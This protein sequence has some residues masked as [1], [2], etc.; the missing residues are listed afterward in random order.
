MVDRYALRS[1]GVGTH[2]HNGVITV[3][4]G[5]DLNYT[6][7]DLPDDLIPRHA[8]IGDQDR[9]GGVVLVVGVTNTG[10]LE[11]MPASLT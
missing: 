4:D 1:G 8:P 6:E 2:D 10:D 9:C 3:I 5:T 7:T 11:T